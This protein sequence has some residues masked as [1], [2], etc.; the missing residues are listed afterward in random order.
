MDATKHCKQQ[1][2]RGKWTVEEKKIHWTDFLDGK[3]SVFVHVLLQFDLTHD[4]HFM[5]CYYAL[6]SKHYF[7]TF[8]ILWLA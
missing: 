1:A 6:F 3:L 7:H 8:N 5:L 4:V 2:L